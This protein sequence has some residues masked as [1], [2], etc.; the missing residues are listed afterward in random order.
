VE[1]TA[2]PLA[3]AF[4]AA[5]TALPPGPDGPAEAEGQPDPR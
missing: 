1:L 5:A 4:H 3:A 2:G